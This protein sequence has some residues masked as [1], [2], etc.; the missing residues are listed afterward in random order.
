MIQA[1][2][3]MLWKRFETEYIPSLTIRKKRNIPQRNFKIGNLVLVFDKNADRTKRPLARIIEIIKVKNGYERTVK[4][5]TKD[6]YYTRASQSTRLFI[7]KV[8]FC[9]IDNVPN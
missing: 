8:P 5:K 7:P 6:G 9:F 1:F 3:T 2:A 4:I